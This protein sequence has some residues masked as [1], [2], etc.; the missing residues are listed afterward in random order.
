MGKF[1]LFHQ[2]VRIVTNQFRL[3]VWHRY[4]GIRPRLQQLNLFG[5]HR[6]LFQGHRWRDY[7][8]RHHHPQYTRVWPFVCPYALDHTPRFGENIR[9][10]RYDFAFLYGVICRYD[11]LGENIKA[12]FGENLLRVCCHDDGWA[13]SC[14]VGDT[15][16]NICSFPLCVDRICSIR[17]G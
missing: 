4:H 14:F 10:S 17:L 5:I 2:V 13:L 8:N 16:A 6:R 7:D 11:Y 9:S 15:Y 3:D 12:V 1:L